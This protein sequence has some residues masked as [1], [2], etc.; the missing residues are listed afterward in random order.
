MNRILRA[1][2]ARA[3][4]T[5]TSLTACTLVLLTVAACGT[6]GADRQSV[7]MTPGSTTISVAGSRSPVDSASVTSEISSSAGISVQSTGNSST[8]S[9]ST[10]TSSLSSSPSSDSAGTT[11]AASTTIGSGGSTDGPGSSSTPRFVSASAGC[12]LD[13][14]DGTYHLIVSWE[15]ADATG[16][17]LSVDN[18]GLVGSYGTYGWH[19]SQDASDLGCYAGDRTQDIDLYSVGGTGARVKKSFHIHENHNRITPPPFAGSTGTTAT[20]TS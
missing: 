20:S 6:A 4:R 10:T 3:G 19:G 8:A 17:A 15:L 7:G 11:A 9:A 1:H 16:L 12:I 5:L 14:N 13:P 2:T 18:P